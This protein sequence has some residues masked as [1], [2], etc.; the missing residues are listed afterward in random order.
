MGTRASDIM[1]RQV[2]AVSPETSWR[3]VARVLVENHISGVPVVDDEG[4]VVGM[5]TEADLILRE[6]AELPKSRLVSFFADLGSDPSAMAEEYRKAHGLVARDVMSREVIAVREDASIE[7]IA[8]IMVRKGV[9]RVIVLSE[10]KLVGIVSRADLIRALSVLPE[11][12]PV[13]SPARDE[14][15]AATLRAELEKQPWFDRA[16][17]RIE[18]IRGVIYL[19]GL[20]ESQEV[21]DAIELAARR[22]AGDAGVRND[23]TIGD[24][25][26]PAST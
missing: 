16:N 23:L 15:L 2:I 3:E 25:W 19:S 5:V 12:R 6:R 17:V 24:S 11:S 21:A 9:R 14:E 8:A 4:R 26:T 10:G 20:V 22:M 18:A 1:T 13:P 7:E